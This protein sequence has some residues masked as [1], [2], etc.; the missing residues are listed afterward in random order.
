MWGSWQVCFFIFDALGQYVG[1][2]WAT[3]RLYFVMGYLAIARHCS[4]LARLPL[5]GCHGQEARC[6]MLSADWHRVAAQPRT[7]LRA[8]CLPVCAPACNLPARLNYVAQ[9][10]LVS[11]VV[12]GLLYIM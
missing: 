1:S 10:D 8:T 2:G 9:V 11:A 4:R 3:G 5:T 6:R 7:C 12:L